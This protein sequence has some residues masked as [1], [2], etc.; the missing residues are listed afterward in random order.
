MIF[1]NIC[2]CHLR[3]LRDKHCSIEGGSF[4][5]LYGYNSVCNSLPVDGVSDADYVNHIYKHH[6]FPQETFNSKIGELFF[7]FI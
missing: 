5:C 7:F 4:V 1:L 6:A 2:I 3:H